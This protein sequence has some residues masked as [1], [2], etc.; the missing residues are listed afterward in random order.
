MRG[1]LDYLASNEPEIY[2]RTH[3]HTVEISRR[4]ASHQRL[5][6][7]PHA[8]QVTVH[9]QSIFDWKNEDRVTEPVYIL[10]FEVLDNLAHDIVRYTT[11]SLKPV[12][13]IVAVDSTG[14]FHERFT[15]VTDPLIKRFLRLGL[16]PP[17]ISSPILGKLLSSVPFS[18]NLTKPYFIPTKCLSLVDTLHKVFPANRPLFSDFSLLPDAVQG[19]M[20]PV[21][22][23]R[24]Q[25]QTV[26]CS[27]MLV[28]RG[29]F[30]I[31]FPTDF[32]LLRE[33]YT[34]LVST[35]NDFFSSRK[36]GVRGGAG[37]GGSKSGLPR[38]K[39]RS[40]REF[41]EEYGEIQRTQLRDGS[42]PMLEY[43]ANQ[44]FLY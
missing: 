34:S 42:N 30:D 39:V 32:R 29:H 35:E 21:V 3:Y 43:Y 7:G 5:R 44:S 40:H 8:S 38:L 41:L 36:L 26:A 11:D 24:F 18:A 27:T 20:A 23:T 6:A 13:S 25:G 4:L 1:I 37:G 19:Q 16:T 22:Q 12:Q 15:P 31:F 10:A 14:D 2:S 17:P 28:S 33:L 9:E